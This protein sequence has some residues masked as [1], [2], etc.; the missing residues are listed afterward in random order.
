MIKTDGA[1][2]E[3]NGTIYRGPVYQDCPHLCVFTQLRMRMRKG[4]AAGWCQLFGKLVGFLGGNESSGDALQ[5]VLTK[6]GA[7]DP[8]IAE[9]M[10]RVY[11]ERGRELGL[12]WGP[13]SGFYG[14]SWT[15]QEK[16]DFR[17]EAVKRATKD[18][19][20][21]SNWTDE[22][23]EDFRLEAVKRTTE[24]WEEGGS[25]A[26]RQETMTLQEYDDECEA[27][28]KGVTLSWAVRFFLFPYGQLD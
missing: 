25:F 27:K 14:S 6:E 28:S 13:I 18:G 19:F 24:A 10:L 20:Y 15:D 1:W 5:D 9:Q 21:G 3:T 7:Y 17:L 4:I 2:R 11:V 12:K 8:V 16:E 26:V 22:E 23:K